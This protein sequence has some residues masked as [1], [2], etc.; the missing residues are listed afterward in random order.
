MV[1]GA[2]ESIKDQMITKHG[3]QDGKHSG[4]LT[5]E[6]FG[7]LLAAE[8]P[9]LSDPEKHRLCVFAVKGSRRIH[10]GDPPNM[11]KVDLST[12]LVQYFHFERAVDEVIQ[13]LKTQALVKRE[14]Q[15][16]ATGSASLAKFKSDNSKEVAR[17]LQIDKEHFGEAQ[18]RGMKALKSR[19]VGLFQE[20]GVSFFDCF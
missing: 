6:D 7:D 15:T 18:S 4:V 14:S 16:E 1:Q 8:F 13:H 2:G 5:A 9:S 3:D 11:A 19:I 12:D 10:G 17:L 20:R